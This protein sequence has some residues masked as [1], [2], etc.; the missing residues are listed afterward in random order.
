[1]LIRNIEKKY[2]FLQIGMWSNIILLSKTIITNYVKYWC[3]FKS[4]QVTFKKKKAKFTDILCD[5]W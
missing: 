4:K 1:M 2:I 5:N 3:N